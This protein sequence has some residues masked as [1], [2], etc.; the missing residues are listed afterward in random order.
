MMAKIAFFIAMLHCVSIGYGERALWTFDSDPGLLVRHDG[1]DSNFQWSIAN[2]TLTMSMTR[3]AQVQRVYMPLTGIYQQGDAFQ[4]RARFRIIS[5]DLASVLLGFWNSFENNIVGTSAHVA[6]D[7]YNVNY[8]NGAYPSGHGGAVFNHGSLYSN[9]NPPIQSNTWYIHEIRYHTLEPSW[10]LSIYSGDGATLLQSVSS[11]ASSMGSVDVFGFAN[12]DSSQSPAVMTVEFDWVSWAVNEPLIGMAEI[13]I[14]LL[15]GSLVVNEFNESSDQFTVAL[16]IQPSANVTLQLQDVSDSNQIALTN[17]DPGT[18]NLDLLFTPDN[19]DTPQTVTIH[20]VQ[21]NI[22]ESSPHLTSIGFSVSGAAEYETTVV[23]DLAVLIFEEPCCT[24]PYLSGDTNFDCTVNFRDLAMVT[25]NWMLCTFPNDPQCIQ[26]DKPTYVTPIDWSGFNTSPV[27][28]QD[29]MDCKTILQ[30]IV[31]SNLNSI[32]SSYNLDESE[33]QY[34]LTGMDEGGVRPACE[35][36]YALAVLLKTGEYEA[37]INLSEE[38]ALDRTIKLLRGIVASHKSNVSSGPGWGDHWQSA[39][40]AALA[41][42]GGNML[43]ND[44]DADIRQMLVNMVVH[45]ADRFVCYDVPYWNGLG[46]DTKAE[47]SAWNSMILNVTVGLL[48]RHSHV[49]AWKLK[50]SELMVSAYCTQDDWQNNHTVLDDRMVKNWLNGYNALEG[51]VVINHDRIHPGYMVAQNM[52]MWGYLTQG[53]ANLPIPETSQFNGD[54]IYE[55]FITKNWPSPPYQAPGGTIYTLGQAPAYYPEGDDWGGGNVVSYYLTDVWAYLLN[56][57]TGLP[58]TAQSWM[59]FRAAD[60]LANPSL[61][62]YS[63]WQIADAYLALWL[64]AH[65]RLEPVSNWLAE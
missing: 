64:D 65:N 40:W 60:L 49:H 20:A 11:P 8:N 13:H 15:D 45:E 59:Q 37:A 44:L 61:G 43:W 55:T 46:G 23:N 21:D 48:A 56:W 31:W 30:N 12:E 22:S 29:Y 47:E 4:V 53:L 50:S 51:G 35:M 17:A 6:L 41:G 3:E 34:I 16:N 14:D 63:G 38:V 27:Y 32:V 57:D 1:S 18:G 9:S 24:G 42:L 10:D 33:Q 25:S 26:I 62:S 5:N 58:Q 7:H 19:W 52:N 28:S 54:L 2:G 36:V 39:L